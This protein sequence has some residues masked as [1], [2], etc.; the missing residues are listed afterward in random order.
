MNDARAEIYQWLHDTVLPTPM[1]AAALMGMIGLW[2]GGIHWVTAPRW[3]ALSQQVHA[4]RLHSLTAQRLHW[5]AQQIP[6]KAQRIAVTE[7]A[8]R[9]ASMQYASNLS[10]EVT[11]LQWQADSK[12]LHI[13]VQGEELSLLQWWDAMGRSVLVREVA[14]W[15]L[16]PIERD[17]VSDNRSATYQLDVTL[18]PER[19][20]WEA[21]PSP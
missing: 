14:H 7:D 1:T 5:E 9:Q 10:L 15:Q 6:I 21:L 4:S 3:Q 2:W 19:W 16:Q 12:T 18:Q 8:L 17:S 13:A 11:T 20:R